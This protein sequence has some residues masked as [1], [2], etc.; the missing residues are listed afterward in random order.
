MPR[1]GPDVYVSRRARS[2]AAIQST[3]KSGPGTGRAMVALSL[4]FAK[5]E[6]CND[7]ALIKRGYSSKYKR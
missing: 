3:P 1:C 5:A 7:V 2:V 6:H 4:D